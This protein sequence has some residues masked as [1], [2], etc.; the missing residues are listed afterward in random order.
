MERPGNMIPSNVKKHTIKDL[1][2]SK[3]DEISILRNDY[4]NN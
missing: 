4:K 2:D 1:M 3:G